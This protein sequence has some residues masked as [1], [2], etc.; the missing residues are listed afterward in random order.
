MRLVSVSVPAVDRVPSQ[1]PEAVH[2]EAF[3]EVQVSVLDPPTTTLVGFAV[4]L[5]VGTSGALT[6]TVTD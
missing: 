6:V 2:D 3:V 1:A 4:K 5:T